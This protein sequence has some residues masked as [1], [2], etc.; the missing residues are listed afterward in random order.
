MGGGRRDDAVP[1]PPQPTRL[2]QVGK[3]FHLFWAKRMVSSKES[4]RWVS[5]GTRE[6]R[7]LCP[8]GW[9]ERPCFYLVYL[10]VGFFVLNNLP[11]RKLAAS[12]IGLVL[13]GI[14]ALVLCH[15]YLG[16]F[17]EWLAHLR[18]W[19]GPALF[20]LLFIIVRQ[21][22]PLFTFRLCFF[23]HTIPSAP[24]LLHGRRCRSR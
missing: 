20:A 13:V 7:M 1:N 23:S 3:K 24:P 12:A 8:L 2:V 19:T 10:A 6:N 15:E 22:Q 11:H 5:G 17:M 4:P 14:G 16:T 18:G 21:K 9:P